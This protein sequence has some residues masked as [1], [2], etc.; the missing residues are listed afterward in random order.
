LGDLNTDP[1]NMIEKNLLECV[2][3][4]QV[5]GIV[6]IEENILIVQIQI[7]EDVTEDFAVGVINVMTIYLYKTLDVVKGIIPDVILVNK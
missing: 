4:F 6:N 3:I 5:L 2:V 7:T 1:M